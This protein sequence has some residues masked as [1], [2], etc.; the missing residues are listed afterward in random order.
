MTVPSELHPQ[1]MNIAK[2]VSTQQRLMVNEL[3][4]G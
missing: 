4:I 3:F 2:P 1:D